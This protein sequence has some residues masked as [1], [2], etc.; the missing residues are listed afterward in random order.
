LVVANAGLQ[1]QIVAVGKKVG[2]VCPKG[3]DWRKESDGYRCACGGHSLTFG[4]LGLYEGAKGTAKE[5]GTETQE[6]DK[7]RKE[8][9]VLDSNGGIVKVSKN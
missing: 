1:K 9:H 4:Q 5:G 2:V 8:W 7:E 6:S 3:S